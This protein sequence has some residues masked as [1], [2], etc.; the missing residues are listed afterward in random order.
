MPYSEICDHLTGTL[1]FEK[2]ESTT[3]NKNICFSILEGPYSYQ[4]QEKGIYCPYQ[5]A[6]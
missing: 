2:Q 1:L 4:H 6:L 5:T 3:S